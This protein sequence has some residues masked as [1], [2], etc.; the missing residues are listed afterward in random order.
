MQH[1]RRLRRRRN[2]RQGLLARSIA[3]S[4]DGC[5]R[6]FQNHGQRRQLFDL[7][8]RLDGSCRCR[9]GRCVP[10]RQTAIADLVL[11]ARHLLAGIAVFSGAGS[12]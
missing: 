7:K 4:S 5:D 11:A 3:A 10:G 6:Q 8:I 9:R 1:E 12:A 2:E